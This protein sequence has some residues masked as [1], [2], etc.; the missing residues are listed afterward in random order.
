MYLYLFASISAKKFPK[1][2]TQNHPQR[3]TLWGLDLQLSNPIEHGLSLKTKFPE[4][5]N[6]KCDVYKTDEFSL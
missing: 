4:V 6:Y 3:K 2:K 5:E 1:L